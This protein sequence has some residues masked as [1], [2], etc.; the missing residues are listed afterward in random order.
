LSYAFRSWTHCCCGYYDDI[1]DVQVTNVVRN[2][3]IQLQPHHI[4]VVRYL[5]D[6]AVQAAIYITKPGLISFTVVVVY[7]YLLNWKLAVRMAV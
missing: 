6:D 7:Y 3:D 1:G 2:G 5:L 4:F